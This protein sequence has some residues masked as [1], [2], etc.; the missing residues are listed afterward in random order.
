M[1]RRPYSVRICL[2]KIS[3][4]ERTTHDS[5]VIGDNTSRGGRSTRAVPVDV[6]EVESPVPA[7]EPRPKAIWTDGQ[8]STL[9]VGVEFEPDLEAWN[10][11][12]E[13]CSEFQGV[14]REVC[15]YREES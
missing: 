1:E 11:L 4:D 6:A 7:R 9:R 3:R 15:L 14:R 5:E 2:P 12:V 10:R 8:D 13:L